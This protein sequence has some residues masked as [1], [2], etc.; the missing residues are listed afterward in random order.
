CPLRDADICRV[1][2]PVLRFPAFQCRV[3]ALGPRESALWH[4]RRD[5]V[6]VRPNALQKLERAL[7]E[8]YRREAALTESGCELANGREPYVARIHDGRN[9][10]GGSVSIGTRDARSSIAAFSTFSR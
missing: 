4:E 9:T 7:R 2:C 6:V 8:L 5:R 10:V 1:A 3:R